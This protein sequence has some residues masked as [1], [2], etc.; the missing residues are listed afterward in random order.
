MLSI[1][2]PAGSNPIEYAS[3]STVKGCV[4]SAFPVAVSSMLSFS[5]AGIIVSVVSVVVSVYS[6]GNN[7]ALTVIPTVITITESTIAIMVFL[8]INIL[9]CLNAE[10]ESWNKEYSA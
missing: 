8:S 1:E 6:G 4:F 9:L 3:V 10:T 5:S 7:T 2:A